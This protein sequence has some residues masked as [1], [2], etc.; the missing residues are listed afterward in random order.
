M[1]TS[2]PEGRDGAGTRKA[3]AEG[4]VAGTRPAS[5]PST[6]EALEARQHLAWGPYPDLI[7][8]DELVARYPNVTGKGVVVAVIDT[9]MDFQHPKLQG[10]W[11]VNTGETPFN[12]RDD[13]N[14]GYVDDY[15]GYDFYRE[16]GEPNDENSHG[17]QMGGIIAGHTWQSGGADYAGIAPDAKIVSLKVADPSGRID[18]I[19]FNRRVERALQWIEKNLDKTGIS[20]ISMSI[21]VNDADFQATFADEV[22]RL[23]QKGVFIIA[24][25]GHFE[26]L[27]NRVVSPAIHPAVY[28]AGMIDVNDKM[29]D[30]GQ[31]GPD[32]DILA[33]SD[34]IPIL[35]KGSAYLI[36]GTASS[37]PT[38]FIAGTAALLKQINPRFTP[39]QMMKIM[40]DSGKP[41]FDPHSQRTYK[42]LDIDDAV[43]LAIEQSGGQQPK[44]NPNPGPNQRPFKGSPF[45]TGKAIQFEDFDDGGQGVSFN[46]RTTRPTG[47]YRRTPV[48]ILPIPGGRMVS[49]VRG[50]EWLEYTM[51]VKESGRFQFQ[52]RLRSQA[53]GG[54]FRVEVDGRPATGALQVADT[55]NRW[56]VVKRGGIDLS[57]GRHVVRIYFIKERRGSVGEFDWFRFKPQ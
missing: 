18:D 39:A 12:N 21:K 2:T 13:D 7:D 16:D 11:W 57:A 49:G 3:V 30:I 15:R 48:G 27:A 52:A 25:S 34:R 23:N 51:S 44:P 40:Q 14:N 47:T 6:V 28:A 29:P 50:G 10:K 37:Y 20:I 4:V 46:D 9:G 32:L 33:P 36:S 5:R 56:E 1:R 35:H 43:K 31:R 26:P 55:S 8:H 17:T 22:T 41:I 42:R 38:P 54:T 53:G 45:K 24:S 19:N